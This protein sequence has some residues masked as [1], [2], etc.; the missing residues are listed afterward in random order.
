[1]ALYIPAGRRR[2]RLI[3][4]G[5]V[6]VVV[7]L[8]IGALIGRAS[9][10]TLSDEV[11]S[12]TSDAQSLDAR[13]EA[14]PLE[15]EQSLSG[16]EGFSTGGG[17]ADALVTISADADALARRAEWLSDARRAALVASIDQAHQVAIDEGSSSDFEAA[18]AAASATVAE[19]FGLATTTTGS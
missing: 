12:V 8:I 6:S 5:V 13:L 1:M 18:I 15:Y 9:A 4:V 2:R 17:P 16:A 19:T 7:G 11:S 3:I 14:L 10:P